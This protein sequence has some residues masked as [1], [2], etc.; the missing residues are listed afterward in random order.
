MAASFAESDESFD[1]EL[2]DDELLGAEVPLGDG[3]DAVFPLHPVR[4]RAQTMH[5]ILTS[6]AHHSFFIWLSDPFFSDIFQ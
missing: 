3:A 1:D 2:L 6:E 5:A 4:A